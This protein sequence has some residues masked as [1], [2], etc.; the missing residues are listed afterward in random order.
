MTPFFLSPFQSLKS[1]QFRVTRATDRLATDRTDRRQ[2]TDRTRMLAVKGVK[3]LLYRV[4]SR[5][6]MSLVNTN[7]YFGAS[8]VA[9]MHASRK[10]ERV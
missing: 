8:L 3:Q 7:R 1:A 5:S 4:I 2:K 10:V 9:F 6:H